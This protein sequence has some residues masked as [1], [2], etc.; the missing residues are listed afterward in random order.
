MLVFTGMFATA[1]LFV[2]Y[3]FKDHPRIRNTVRVWAIIGSLVWL[4]FYGL[5]QSLIQ[6][7]S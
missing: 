2:L 6:L 3:R 1:L 4:V 5:A 7:F